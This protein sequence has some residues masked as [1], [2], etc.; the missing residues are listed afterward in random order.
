MKILTIFLLSLLT[1]S[2]V[3][4]G[5]NWKVSNIY[6]YL[7]IYVWESAWTYTDD[8]DFRKKS[9]VSI[10]QDLDE[11][12][13]VPSKWLVIPV[14]YISEHSDDYQNI[15]DFKAVDVNKYLRFW[16]LVFP[17]EVNTSYWEEWN[18]TIMWH[19]SYLKSDSWRYKTHFQVLIWL[20]EWK[21]IWIYKKENLDF[22]RYRYKVT[23]SYETDPTDIDILEDNGNKSELTLFT[24]TPIWWDAWRWIIKS[25]FIQEDETFNVDEN[26]KNYIKIKLID[27]VNSIENTQQRNTL[28]NKLIY[29]LESIKTT[30]SKT[31]NIIDYIIYALK[32]EA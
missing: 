32:K 10:D 27:K 28:K 4:A 13:V 29:K 7:P 21:E 20:E 26:I 1:F 5:W 31:Q 25:E 6:T 8:I 3:S 2:S 14:N 16:S 9:V 23:K 17:K 11:Y 24:C 30:N 22:K 18:I 15:I 19:S 12:L